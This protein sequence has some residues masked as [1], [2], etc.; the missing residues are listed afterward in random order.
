M[1]K[2]SV[3]ACFCLLASAS[4]FAQKYFTREGKISFFSEASMEKIEA[5]N[6]KATSVLDAET[7]KM[8]F[9]VLIKAFQFEK[10]LMQEHFNE[11]YLESSKYPKAVFKGEIVDFAN[12]VNLKK[13][14][15]YAVKVKGDLTIHGVTKQVETDGVF[16]V[17]GGVISAVSTFDV[18]LADHKVEIP[19]LVKDN[20]AKTVKVSVDVQY[21]ELKS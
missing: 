8:E 9:A 20:I 13:D 3:L 16:K 6:Q 14:G 21:Q 2:L 4:L 19:A 18:A 10:A 11:N 17:A 1:K 12:K 5:H 15:E 7:G